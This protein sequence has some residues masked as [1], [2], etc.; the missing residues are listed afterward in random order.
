MK[1]T[2]EQLRQIIKEELQTV[3]EQESAFSNFKRNIKSLK[4]KYD[5]GQ[6]DK[7]FYDKTMKQLKQS[8]KEQSD[9]EDSNLNKM[10]T[11]AGATAAPD[12][13]QEPDLDSFDTLAGATVA[14]GENAKPSPEQ[15]PQLDQMNTAAPQQDAEQMARKY[16][17]VKQILAK[18]VKEL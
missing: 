7:N 17:K 2:N 16:A 11:L 10:D 9:L 3:L 15:Q 12:S 18:L 8:Y 14:P 1:I 13:S 4:K 5:S 6:I